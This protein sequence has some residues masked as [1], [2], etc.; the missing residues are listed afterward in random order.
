MKIEWT[1]FYEQIAQLMHDKVCNNCKNNG[2]CVYHLD[3]PVES[4]CD[5]C[6]VDMNGNGDFYCTKFARL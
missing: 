6:E 4:V 2:H 1:E 3:S 5:D